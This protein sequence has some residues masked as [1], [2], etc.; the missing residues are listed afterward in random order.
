MIITVALGYIVLSII[1]GI[2]GSDRNLGFWGFFIASLIV[3]PI[4]TL[5]FL[6]IT[7]NKS[8]KKTAK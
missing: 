2:I 5:F 3:S 4:L 6:L 8:V 7:K 1:A